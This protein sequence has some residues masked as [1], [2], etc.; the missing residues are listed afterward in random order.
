[1]YAEIFALLTAMLRGFSSIPTKMGL[2]YSNPNTSAFTYLLFNTVFLWFMTAML[3]PLDEIGIEGLGYFILAGICAPG[4]ARI[5]MDT[6]VKRLGVTVSSPIV[7]TNTLFSVLIAI[8]F[9]GEEITYFIIAG[10]LMI[11]VGVNLITWRNRNNNDWHKKDVI[12][13]LTAA[14]FFA[15]STNLRKIGLNQ[16]EYPIAG[17]A[18]TSTVSLII[19]ICSLLVGRQMNSIGITLKLNKVAMKYFS[20][21]SVTSSVAYLLYFLAL[22]GSKITRIQPI[23]GTNPLWAIIFSYIFLRETERITLRIVLG[24]VMIVLGIAL[25]FF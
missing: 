8:I 2:E 11:F 1:M 22:S 10:A 4:L 19:L 23:G 3:Y 13:P 6:G 7:S 18:I 15:L 12:F 14:F 21:A 16:M 20:L 25:I 24:A 17:A 9:L 5:F